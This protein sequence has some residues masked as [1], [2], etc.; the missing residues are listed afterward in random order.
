MSDKTK[1]VGICKSGKPCRW[2]TWNGRTHCAAHAAQAGDP[3]AVAEMHRRGANGHAKATA[4]R[5]SARRKVCSLRTVD[6]C[7][8]E[9]ERIVIELER[10]GDPLRI[11]VKIA[12]IQAAHAL[13][14]SNV[15]E[16][17]NAALRAFIHEHHPNARPFLRAV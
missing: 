8:A 11:K 12:A 5:D 10:P 7:R 6:D 2:P 1:C 17:E 14:R 9:L 13:L 15:L 3:E 16:E 4:R